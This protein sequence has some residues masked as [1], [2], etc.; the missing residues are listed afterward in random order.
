VAFFIFLAFIFLTPNAALAQEVSL[1]L[2]EIVTLAQK[3]NP[4]IDVARQQC[5]QSQGIL[6]QSKSSY[7]PHLSVGAAAAR[8]KK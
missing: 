3:N 6:T 4:L 2:G 7:L 1:N 5:L 8:Q